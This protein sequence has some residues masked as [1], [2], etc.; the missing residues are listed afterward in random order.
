[1]ISP[2]IGCGYCCQTGMCCLGLYTH[3][4]G[5]KQCPSLILKEGR[6]WCQLALDDPKAAENLYIGAGCSSSLCNTQREACM[7]GELEQ[8]LQLHS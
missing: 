1:M 3:G 4:F 5:H 2:C 8:Y 7:K 6:F